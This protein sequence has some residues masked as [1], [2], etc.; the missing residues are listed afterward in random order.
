MTYTK[1]KLKRILCPDQTNLKSEGTNYL[2]NWS[3]VN[4][5]PMR[6]AIVLINTVTDETEPKQPDNGSRLNGKSKWLL[7]Y[8]V[9]IFNCEILETMDL[10]NGHNGNHLNCC[11]VKLV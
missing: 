11:L 5:Y 2:L 8:F 7:A 3:K 4:L 9:D 1:K 10:I 6:T